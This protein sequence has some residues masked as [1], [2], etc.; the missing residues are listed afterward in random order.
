MTATVIGTEEG[1]DSPDVVIPEMV[2]GYT[3]TSIGKKA[4]QRKQSIIHVKTPSTLLNIGYRA[5]AESEN[6]QTIELSES[7]QSI[8]D[9]AF[10][11]TTSLTE[12]YVPNSVTNMG[13]AFSESGIVSIH[14]SESMTTISEYCFSLCKNLQEI[15]IPNSVTTIGYNAFSD[16]TSLQSVI[17]PASVRELTKNIGGYYGTFENCPSLTSIVVDEA[18]PYFDS[19]ENCNAIISTAD[20]CL[21]MGCNNTTI[22]QSVQKICQN[23]FEGSG[24]QSI[25]IPDNVIDFGEGIFDECKNLAS[26]VLPNSMTFIPDVMFSNCESLSSITLPNTI[27]SIGV[28]SFNHCYNL[29]QIQIPDGVTTIGARA[30]RHTGLQILYTPKSLESIG[31]SAFRG[32][33]ELSQITLSQNVK[34]IERLAFADCKQLKSVYSLII[35]PNELGEKAFENYDEETGTWSFS[36]ALL[37]IPKGT[38]DK[39][40]A[41]AGWN[42]FLNILEEDE[43]GIADVMKE[44]EVGEEYDLNGRRIANGKLLKGIHII[45]MSDG[46]T[47]KVMLK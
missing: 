22:P 7:L 15:S 30:F 12:V 25:T 1:F 4:F 44:K 41:T 14:L 11:K 9:A 18:N 32:C 28:S 38:K 36:S 20:N 39:Y 16:C 31:E 40:K 27:T 29:T 26:V 19:R 35:E 13:G 34:S 21:L 43:D 24:I 8:D 3:V 10:Y 42:Q 45:R 23:A 2:N 5:F 6:L 37:Y 33:A 47:R 46:T 17:I